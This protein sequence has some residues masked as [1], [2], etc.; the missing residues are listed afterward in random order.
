MKNKKILIAHG[1]GG[2]MMHDLI[3]GLLLEKL[4]NPVLRELSDSAFIDY[5]QRIAFSTD[6][7]V[8]SP[9]FFPGG[10]IGKLSVCGTVNDLLMQGAIPEFL[11]LAFIIEEGLDYALLEKI[12]DSIRI[13]ARQAGVYI[14]T[15][16]IK[17]VERGAADKIFINTSG[18]GRIITRGRL[19]IKNISFGDEIILSG[20][21]GQHGLAV[22]A[23]RKELDLGFAIKSDCAPLNSLLAPIIKKTDAIKFMRDPTRGGVATTL[24]EAAESS[25]LGIVIEERDIPVSSQV[26]A[27]CELLGMDP[28]YL[29]NEGCALLVVKSGQAQ[30][31]LRLLKKHPLGCYARIIGR[32]VKEPRGKV[33]LN[34]TLGT[35]RI[36]DMLTAEHLP[37]IC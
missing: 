28:L 35:Q 12:V 10:D 7:F 29:A 2:R 31:V 5:R 34:T 18:I 30:K 23:K 15:G 14:A 22:L 3:K 25:G 1:S 6:S 19:S 27:A 16:D 17:V 32:V 37:R 20:K 33:V 8:V 11:S 36:V 21:M 4:D 9:L 13:T 26:T 24:N